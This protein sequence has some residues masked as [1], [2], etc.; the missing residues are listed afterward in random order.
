MEVWEI[1]FDDILGYGN[2]GTVYSCY[3]NDDDRSY[4]I[5]IFK[6]DFASLNEIEILNYLKEFQFNYVG[7][8]VDCFDVNNRTAIVM[9]K[10][11][12]GNEFIYL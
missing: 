6:S 1:D 10:L 9:E 4:A 3:R 7:N 12:G 5:K 11:E 8:I 2:Y